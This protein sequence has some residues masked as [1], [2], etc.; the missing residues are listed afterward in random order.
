MVFD[1]VLSVNQLHS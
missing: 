1:T